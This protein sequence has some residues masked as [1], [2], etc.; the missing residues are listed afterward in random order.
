VYAC[1]IRTELENET[2]AAGED[3]WH[4][5]EERVMVAEQQYTDRLRQ[6]A[7]EQGFLDA[8]FNW[9]LDL[10]WHRTFEASITTSYMRDLVDEAHRGCR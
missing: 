9:D 3:C 4:L 1:G 7:V 2:K 10:P 5:P 8:A 6:L